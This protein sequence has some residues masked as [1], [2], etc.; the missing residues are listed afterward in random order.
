MTLGVGGSHLDLVDD[1]RR[2]AWRRY[3][4]ERSHGLSSWLR[5]WS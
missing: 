1:L 3:L 5:S 2:T 4:E